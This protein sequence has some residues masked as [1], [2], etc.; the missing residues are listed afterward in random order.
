MQVSPLALHTSTPA[1]LKARQDA[2][3][4]GEP[5]LVLRDGTGAQVIV[6]LDGAQPSLT[7]GRRPENDV[8]LPWDDRASRLHAELHRVGDE[9]VLADEGLSSNGT[10]VGEA[11]LVGRRRL[12]NGDVVRVGGTL[13]AFCAAEDIPGTTSADDSGAAL[14]ITPAQ[15]RVLV[16]L[17]RPSLGGRAAAPPTNGELARELYLSVDSIKT[18]MKAL[19]DAFGLDD[20]APSAKRATLVERAV[21]LGIVTE[22]DASSRGR[23]RDAS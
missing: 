18:H 22:R 3:R 11:K 14:S 2:Q 8:A 21:R 23:G 5:F 12:R 1:E 17:C 20:V 13:I 16:A 15:R 6:R 4:A 10:Y 9:W 7:I 19:F